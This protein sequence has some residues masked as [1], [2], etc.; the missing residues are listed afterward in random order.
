MYCSFTYIYLRTCGYVQDDALLCAVATGGCTACMRGRAFVPWLRAG[1][2]LAPLF[3][4]RLPP[5]DALWHRCRLTLSPLFDG[6]SDMRRRP[7]AFLAAVIIVLVPGWA[8][9]QDRPSHAKRTSAERRAA[10]AVGEPAPCPR[11]TWKDDPVC[12]GEGDRDALPVPSSASIQR[13]RTADGIEIKPTAKLNPRPT[14][15]GGGAYQSEIIY[16]SNGNSVTSNYGG[17]LSLHLPF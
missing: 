13:E 11:A 10:P 16:Q 5:N 4:R 1:A 17:G 7:T 3:S 12:F 2:I 15:P 8:N 6:F 9:A 14:G